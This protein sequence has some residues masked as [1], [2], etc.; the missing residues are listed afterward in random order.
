MRTTCLPEGRPAPRCYRFLLNCVLAFMATGT[1]AVAQVQATAP[2][3]ATYRIIPLSPA[4]YAYGADINAHGQVAFTDPADG[5]P[6]ASF[7]DGTRVRDL[8]T[9]GGAGATAGAINDRGQVTGGAAVGGPAGVTHAYRWGAKTGMRDIARR[10]SGNSH[11]SA[12]NKHGEVAGSAVFRP[13]ESGDSH[14]FFWSPSTGMRDIGTLGAPFSYAFALNDAGTVTGYTASQNSPNSMLG[15]RWTRARGIHGIGTVEDEFTLATDINEAGRIV[16]ASVF[17]TGQYVHAFLWTPRRGL[18][19][20]GTGTGTRSSARKLNDRGMVIGEVQDAFIFYHGFIWTRDTGIIE[21]GADS[22]AVGTSANDLNN[23]GQ[24]VG[25][26]G[27]RAIIWTR[28]GGVV[29]L[30]SR[31]AGAP[32]GLVLEYGVA[33]SDNGSIVARGNTGL[34]LLVPAGASTVAPVLG[35]ITVTGKARPRALLTLSS[36]FQD[37]DRR[38][39]HSAR[40]DWGDGTSSTGTVS[41]KNGAGSVSGQHPFQSPGVYP[42]RLTV[43]D[44]TRRSTR[45]QTDVVV[46]GR[47]ARTSGEGSF[48]SPPGASRAAPAQTG[49]ARFAFVAPPA[50][51]QTAAAAPTDAAAPA[52]LKFSAPGLML[53]NGQFAATAIDAGR[54]EAS[55]TATV[56]GKPGYR[57]TLSAGPDTEGGD[58]KDRFGIRVWHAE[59]GSNTEVVAYDNLRNEPVPESGGAGTVI[60]AGA[61]ASGPD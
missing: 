54:L 38:D 29:D 25:S 30:N 11:G 17:P 33:I 24:V 47:E 21:L 5:V 32:P 9:L 61:I 57:F 6:R 56:N 10:G 43:T 20:L 13:A 52:Q 53:D 31:L 51:A 7:Y 49:I 37:A 16:G 36:S 39:T 22:Q 2:L 28:A 27:N 58:G 14:A 3:P 35:P 1:V 55:G 44:N 12:I 15:F 50:A 18:T 46:R 19:D 23:H 26:V 40:W 34:V 41:E 42:V 4:P 48:V 60:E 8:G 59:P 45:V